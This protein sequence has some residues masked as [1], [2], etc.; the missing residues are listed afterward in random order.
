MVVLVSF[1]TAIE[2]KFLAGVAVVLHGYWKYTPSHFFDCWA[3]IGADVVRARARARP[4]FIIGSRSGIAVLRHRLREVV[5]SLEELAGRSYAFG[6]ASFFFRTGTRIAAE[7]FFTSLV[8]LE[9]CE[10]LQLG[11]RDTL[12]GSLVRGFTFPSILFMH[13]EL[14]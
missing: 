13:T 3:T 12:C 1:A 7:I 4:E 10:L 5:E 2:G 6:R 11:L 14:F 8:T 9:A